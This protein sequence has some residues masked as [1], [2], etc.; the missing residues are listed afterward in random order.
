M[1]FS[2][3]GP[4]KRS[5]RYV[6]RYPKSTVTAKSLQDPSRA[7]GDAMCCLS[8]MSQINQHRLESLE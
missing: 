4:L 6:L 1:S 5:D 7:T 2:G 8:D 3:F